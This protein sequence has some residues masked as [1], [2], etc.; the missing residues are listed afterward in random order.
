MKKH[1]FTN[2]QYAAKYEL[3]LNIL[4]TR[5]DELTMSLRNINLSFAQCILNRSY[6]STPLPDI[7][8]LLVI[9]FEACK[10]IK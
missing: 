5:F 10:R 9:A 3:C 7:L 2:P 1:A 8:S 6:I 4:Q